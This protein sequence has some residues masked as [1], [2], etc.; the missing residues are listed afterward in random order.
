MPRLRAAKDAKVPNVVVINAAMPAWLSKVSTGYA[1][2]K[3]MADAAAQKYAV[4]GVMSVR[5]KIK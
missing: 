1:T 3:T 4:D 2:G 5:Q